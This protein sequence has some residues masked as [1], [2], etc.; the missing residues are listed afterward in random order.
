MPIIP[1]LYVEGTDDIAVISALLSRHH[2][3]TDKGN[4]YLKI[5][6]LKNDEGVID[7]MPIA[8]KAMTSQPVGFVVDIDIESQRRWDSI[9]GHLRELNL[10]LPPSCPSDG[11]IGRMPN[12]QYEFG[13]W[14]MPDCASDGQKIE[15]LIKS[16]L[17]LGDPLWPHA[18]ISTDAVIA[19]VDI[20]NS[21]KKP[22]E[23]AYER[24]ADQDRIKAEVR[25]WLAWQKEPGVP[26]G[27][28]INYRILGCDS[29]QALAFLRWLKRVYNL[30]LDV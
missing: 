30:P 23:K 19:I 20:A 26:L 12:Y 16:L 25:A 13:I 22:E 11:F 18:T 2:I 5:V 3:N 9:C 24:F 1:T 7:G 27:A 8:I 10:I 6:S 17:P 4:K 15:H 29:P 28:A 14:L 21:A